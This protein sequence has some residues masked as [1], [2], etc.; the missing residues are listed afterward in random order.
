MLLRLAA[1]LLALSTT[2]TTVT[3]SPECVRM[4]MRL[5][6][7]ACRP[8]QAE[9]TRV[10]ASVVSA[11]CGTLHSVQLTLPVADDGCCA[12]LRAF[13]EAGCGCDPDVGRLAAVG[14]YTADT[15]RGGARLATVSRCADP[16]A[17][18]APL[19]NPCGGNCIP[20]APAG[21]QPAMTAGG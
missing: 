17:G 2:T 9:S 12:D 18:Y 11:D 13:V 10:A 21:E 15:V 14:G 7:G 1:L 5:S 19:N 6:S 4:A 8:M 20:V 3:A 16:A